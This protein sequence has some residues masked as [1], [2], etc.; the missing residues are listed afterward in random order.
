MAKKMG[1]IEVKHWLAEAKSCEERQQKEL[2]N[3][4]HYPMLVKYYEGIQYTDVRDP[5]VASQEQ[6]AAIN[7]FFPNT[8]A[9]ISELMYQNPSIVAEARKPEAEQ[10]VELMQAALTYAADE[11]KMLIENRLALFDMLYAGFSA[12]E[13]GHMIERDQYSEEMNEKDDTGGVIGKIKKIINPQGEEQAEEKEAQ[14]S[15]ITEASYATNEKTYVRRWNPLNVLF[16]W[17][18][19]R[20]RDSRYILKKIYYTK[21]EFDVKYPKFKDKV[22]VSDQEAT[23]A[24]HEDAS[25]RKTILLYEFQIKK[26]GGEYWNLCVCPNYQL[27]PMDY[28]KRPYPHDGFNMKIGTLHKYGA[29]YPI[30]VAQ[31]NKKLQDDTNN[32]ITHMMETAERNI[33][34]IG[35]NTDAVTKEGIEALRSPHVNDI[36]SVKGSP[37]ANIMPIHPTNVSV[38]NKELLALFQ[39]HKDKMWSVSETRMQGTSRAKFATELQIQESGFQAKQTDIQEGLRQLIVEELECLKDI[40][41]VFWDQPYFFKVTGGPK[42]VW[43]VGVE[44]PMTG[45][46]INP[47]TRGNAALTDI[48]TGD[49]FLKVDIS[50]ALRPSKEKRKKDMVDFATWITSPQVMQFLEMNGMQVN[51]EIFKRIAQE[52]NFNTDQLIVPSQMEPPPPEPVEMGENI[53]KQ[54]TEKADEFGNKQKVEQTQKE[55]V[56]Q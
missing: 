25:H 12:V 1:I 43:Y 8:N 26:K 5:G 7:E 6:I 20:F 51:P 39:N 33:P 49:Y 19:E 9:L 28:Y 14:Q 17:R 53:T 37:D 27:E 10:G 46:I 22:S 18:A 42:P 3:R 56:F 21:A 55:K 34:K 4:N 44:D 38:E 52:F 16:D 32:Y 40:I 45:T 15:E 11:T 13:V 30:S 36:V 2:V 47:E 48:L 50:T 54:V 24:T 23:Y 31:E 41:A 35:V 29:M